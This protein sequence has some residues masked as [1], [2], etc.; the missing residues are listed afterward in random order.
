MNVICLGI[1]HQTASVELREKFAVAD[2]DL[3]GAATALTAADGIEE[4]VI[5][6][7]CNRVEFYAAAD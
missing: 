1:N 6:S 5:V 4:V 2:A 3:I 7:T